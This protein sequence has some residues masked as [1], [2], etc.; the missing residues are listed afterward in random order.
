MGNEIT[1]SVIKQG[2]KLGGTSDDWGDEL[3]IGAGDRLRGSISPN[4]TNQI[5][6]KQIVGSGNIM[7]DESQKGRLTPVVNHSTDLGFENGTEKMIAQFFGTAG[8]P[9]EQN[10]GEGDYLHQFTMNS[11]PNPVYGT[12][13][14]ELT[15][16]KVL[17]LPSVAVSQITLSSQGADEQYMQVQSVL[18]GNDIVLDSTSNTNATLTS[19]TFADQECVRIKSSD[20][21]YLNDQSGSDFASGDLFRIIS[22]NFTMNRPQQMFGN[23]HGAAGNTAPIMTDLPTG[24]LTVTLEVLGNITEFTKWQNETYQ[25]CKL[26]SEGTQIGSGDNKN[27]TIYCPRMKLLNPPQVPITSSGFNQV[28]LV[29]DLFQAAANPT[30]LASTMPY[31]EITNERTTAYI[32]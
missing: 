2:F 27:F 32:A 19:A 22:Y 11:S 1:G 13:A 23:I 28:T 14:Y 7:Q 3:V 5:L 15:S 8:A 10:A 6:Q 12:F 16:D 18:N 26:V 31:I 17:V 21:F 4:Y 30:G 29:Y 20:E 25:K 9:T 24:Q